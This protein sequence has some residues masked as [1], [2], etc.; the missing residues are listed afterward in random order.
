MTTNVWKLSVLES[1]LT[2][3]SHDLDEVEDTSNFI[4]ALREL[5]PYSADIFNFRRLA[6]QARR[7]AHRFDVLAEKEEEIA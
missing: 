3:V 7:I 6:Q 2:R 1:K 5:S 4:N